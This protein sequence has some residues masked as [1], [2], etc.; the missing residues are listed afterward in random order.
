VEGDDL[1]GRDVGEDEAAP[2]VVEGEASQARQG[3][4]DGGLFR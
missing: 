2:R 3:A 1:G 4:L